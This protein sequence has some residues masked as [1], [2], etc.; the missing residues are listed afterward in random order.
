MSLKDLDSDISIYYDSDRYADTSYVLN[1]FYIPVLS[2]AVYYR[3]LTG[4]FSSS[5]LGAAAKGIS[6]F[7][8]NGGKMELVCWEVINEKDAKAILDGETKTEEVL[9]RQI[10]ERWD[11]ECIED[12]L[13]ED[14]LSVMAWMIAK[15]I[16]TIRIASRPDCPGI[17]H[18]KSGILI[19]SEG[20]EIIFSGSENESIRG[21][22]FNHE[23]FHVYKSWDQRVSNYYAEEKR[24]LQDVWEGKGHHTVIFSLPDALKEKI[25]QYNKPMSSK[26]ILE[27]DLENRI[28]NEIRSERSDKHHS[29]LFDIPQNIDIRPYQNDAINKW[30]DNKHRG[31]FKMATGTGKTITS[32]ALAANLYREKEGK[33]TIIIACPYK[34]LV[35]QWENTAKL[36]NLKPILG[37]ESTASWVKELNKKIT[38]FN[39]GAIDHFCLITTHTT[40]GLEDMRNSIAKITRNQDVLLIVDEVHHFSARHLSR[41]LPE[42]VEHRL[43]LSATPENWYDEERDKALTEYF[44]GIIYDYGLEQAIR[45]NWLTRYFYYPHVVELTDSETEIYYELTEK[46]SKIVRISGNNGSSFDDNPALKILL[47]ARARIVT[48]ARNKVKLLHDL[49]TTEDN[50][51]HTL[52]YCGDGRYEDEEDE[53]TDY[54]LRDIIIEMMGVELELKV[55][56]FTAEES[57]K[58][59]EELLSRFDSGDLQAL[60]AIRCLDEGVDVPATETAYIMA[61]STNPRQFI[62]RRGRILRKHKNKKYSHIHDFIVIPPFNSR[63]STEAFNMDRSILERELKRV[64]WFT[65]LAENGARADKMLTPLKERYNLLDL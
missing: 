30:F 49:L 5:I 9:S 39:I 59:R 44:D 8:I 12:K 28:L 25:L 63:P 46:I 52:I 26:Q 57:Q 20:N 60:V 27:L 36:F 4:S 7:I 37:F 29:N 19:D 51:H 2:N 24:T 50:L 40:F 23:K 33:L 45:N 47:M 34:H 56:P 31:I 48:G 35:R 64:K 16:L 32:L 58:E 1:N 11:R 10:I 41:T 6:Q 18:L 65:E 3:R 62:Q 17:F 54:R 14:H 21:W 13:L 43:G 22:K 55:H 61:S 15:G 38:S 53:D 42:N